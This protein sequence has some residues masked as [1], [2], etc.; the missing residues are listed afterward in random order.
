MSFET[1]MMLF[2]TALPLLGALALL[3]VPKDRRRVFE[4]GATAILTLSFLLSLAFWFWY[5]RGS[6]AVQW[7]YAVDW[8]P[9]LGIKFSVGMDGISL[10]LWLLT[11]FIG[12]IAAAC[13]W[14]AI[15][16]R[17]KEFYIWLLVMQF[18][19]LGVFFAQDMFLFYLFWELMLVPMYFLIAIWGGP[20]RLY[21]AIKL[22]L[23]TLVGSVLMLVAILAIYFLQYKTTGTYDFSIASFHAMAG[24]IAQQT[25]TFQTLLALA[26]FLGFAIKV[27]MFPFHTWLPDAHVQAPTAGS[28]ILAGILLK[29]GTYGFVRFLL[30]IAP[31]ATRALMP[32]FLGLALIGVIYGALVAMI[33]P[34]MKKLVAYSSVSHLGLCMLGLFALNPNG[35]MGGMFQMVNHGISTS[36]LF[37]IVGIVYER[38]HT[39][40][41]ADFGGLSK[42]MPVYATVFMIMTMSSI[43]L[44]GLNGFI[45]E[46]AILQGAFQ[47]FPWVAI[48]ATSGIVL[49]AAYMLWLYQRTMFGP[50]QEVN[51]KMADLNVREV[52]YF[53]PLILAAFWIGLRPVPLMQILEKPIAK[54]VEQIQPGYLEQDAM[55]AKAAQLRRA[56]EVG[57]RGMAAPAEHPATPEHGAPVPPVEATPGH[58]GH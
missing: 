20:Q 53:A 21:A 33:Q 16:E 50:L 58:G 39:R 6:A 13:S 37:L 19:M 15:E 26:F 25:K 46:F 36:G 32:W 4:V 3:F 12:P 56:A 52:L 42:T 1:K 48:A 11:T 27:P 29:M 41:I 9:S 31:D 54:L 55:A 23:Y 22:F 35:I 47:A 30:P 38:R 14:S 44:P 17:H 57:M 34:D 43:G 8:I 10:V 2:V 40:Q 49:G 5:D 45:G 28:V 18:S 24:T 51:A 7:A